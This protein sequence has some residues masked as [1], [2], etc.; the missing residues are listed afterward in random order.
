ME[1]SAAYL[2]LCCF[3][4]ELEPRPFD[5]EPSTPIDHFIVAWP[6]NGSE[7][8]VDLILNRTH[9]FHYAN[10]VVLMLTS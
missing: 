9:C 4:T 8:G 3:W 7:A 2:T 6:L 5:P 10:Q 1:T